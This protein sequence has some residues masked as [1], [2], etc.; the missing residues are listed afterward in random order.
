MAQIF[1]EYHSR[2][3]EVLLQQLHVIMASKSPDPNA[4]VHLWDE[5]NLFVKRQPAAP[6]NRQE[7]QPSLVREWRSIL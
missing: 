5:L 1:K 7:L 2:E 6:Y 3:T 4:I